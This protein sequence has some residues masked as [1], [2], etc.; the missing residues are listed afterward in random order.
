M[1]VRELIEKL[2]E[3][4]PELGV[5]FQYTYYGGCGCDP[6]ENVVE[7]DVGLVELA[8]TWEWREAPGPRG[9][10]VKKRYIE[11]PIVRLSE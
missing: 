8:T 10:A 2:Q 6:W 11:V 7:R 1:K 9:G 4:D 5:E 3:F